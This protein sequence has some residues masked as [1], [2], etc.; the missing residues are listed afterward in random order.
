MGALSKASS[1]IGEAVKIITAIAEQTNLLALNA[2]IEAARAGGAGKGFA[3]VAAEVKALASQT[4]KATDEIGQQIGGIQTAIEESV[5]Y[6]QEINATINRISEISSMIAN[7]MEEQGSA[8]QGIARN[9]Q[10]AATKTAQVATDI[11]QVNR[12]AS[13]TGSASAQVLSSA[14]GLST[15]SVRLKTEVEKF[16]SK[17]RAA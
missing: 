17:V 6:S 4:A 14:Q 8:M 7:A 16:L 10:Q 5:V 15:E 13:E 2:T 9:V 3:V 12:G 1:R 11:T